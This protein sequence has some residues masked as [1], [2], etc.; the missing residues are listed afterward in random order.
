MIAPITLSEKS[1]RTYLFSV[2]VVWL[3]LDPSLDSIRFTFKIGNCTIGSEVY[4][5][6]GGNLNTKPMKIETEMIYDTE[7]KTFEPLRALLKV[8]S[9][10][11]K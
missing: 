6:G 5:R 4:Q 7:T 1:I 8:F 9:V 11:G 3:K 10:R 2:S